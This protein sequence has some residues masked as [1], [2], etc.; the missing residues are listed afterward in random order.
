M[1]D[2]RHARAHCVLFCEWSRIAGMLSDTAFVWIPARKRLRCVVKG[3]AKR[4]TRYTQRMAAASAEPAPEVM[5]G[6]MSDVA[7]ASNAGRFP[8][9]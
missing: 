9:V 5:C 3:A 8:P 1:A 7:D 4:Q 2:F 6:E